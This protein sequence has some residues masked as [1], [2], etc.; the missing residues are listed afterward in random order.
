MNT[1]FDYIH[2]HANNNTKKHIND[3]KWRVLGYSRM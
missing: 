2:A 3:V 1:V